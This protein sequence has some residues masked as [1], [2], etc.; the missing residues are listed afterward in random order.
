MTEVVKVDFQSKKKVDSKALPEHKPFVAAE[1][2]VFK[3]F[4]EGLAQ[5]VEFMELR[6]GDWRRMV[7]I[8]HDPSIQPP[9]EDDGLGTMIAVSDPGVFP[10]RDAVQAAACFVNQFAELIIE[11]EEDDDHDS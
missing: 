8:I 11:E 1:D 9:G 6:G 7:T 5:A 10:Q 2:P 4:V 3:R